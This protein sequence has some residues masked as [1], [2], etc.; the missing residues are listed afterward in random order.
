MGRRLG[1]W[2][3]FELARQNIS[4]ACQRLEHQ[5]I[6]GVPHYEDHALC[7][8]FKYLALAEGSV[9]RAKEHCQQGNVFREKKGL[10]TS[11][12]GLGFFCRGWNKPSRM[13]E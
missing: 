12:V 9:E 10:T 11:S 2:R 5:R 3:V 6:I 7:R 13:H 4:G 8:C 1:R